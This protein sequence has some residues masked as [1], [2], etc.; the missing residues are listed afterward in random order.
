MRERGESAVD[1]A[2]SIRTSHSSISDY[3]HGKRLPGG[4]ILRSLAMHYGV[5]AD[6]LLCLTSVRHRSD[7]GQ[8]LSYQEIVDQINA[9]ARIQEGTVLAWLIREDQCVL[10]ADEA[11]EL[12]RRQRENANGKRSRSGRPPARRKGET[13]Q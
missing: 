5:S 6:W 9:G 12:A 10:S 7:I 13:H 1:L 11:H 8:F 4:E 2:A 3:L